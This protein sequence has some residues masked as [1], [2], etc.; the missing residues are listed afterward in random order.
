[1]SSAAICSILIC[2]ASIVYGADQDRME[3]GSAKTVAVQSETDIKIDET[4]HNE[5][6]D[7][8][9]D[10]AGPQKRIPN[11]KKR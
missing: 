5:S 10:S 2:H 9:Q 4:T 7:K 11:A 6:I 3:H 1:M 8:S